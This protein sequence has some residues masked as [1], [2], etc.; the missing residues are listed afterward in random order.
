M[1]ELKFKDD[2]RTLKNWKEHSEKLISI[3]RKNT[4]I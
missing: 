2:K 1:L 3:Q 4:V